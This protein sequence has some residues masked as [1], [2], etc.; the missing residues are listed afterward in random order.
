MLLVATCSK[1]VAAQVYSSITLHSRYWHDRPDIMD[2]DDSRGANLFR[3]RHYGTLS[4]YVIW[5]QLSA[6]FIKYNICTVDLHNNIDRK[7]VSPNV[8]IVGS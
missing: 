4:V 8:C 7:L 5:G 2:I 6:L 1:L 3:D